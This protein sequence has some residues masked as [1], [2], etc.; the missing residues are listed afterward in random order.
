MIIPVVVV[1]LVRLLAHSFACFALL[2]RHKATSV[3]ENLSL[4]RAFLDPHLL[5]MDFRRGV[6]PGIPLML[7][8]PACAH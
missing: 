3:C 5:R 7:P 2:N 1:F 6:T 8:F 4:E